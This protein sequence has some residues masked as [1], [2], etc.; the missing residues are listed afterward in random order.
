MKRLVLSILAAAALLAGTARAA[1]PEPVTHDATE[2]KTA[3]AVRVTG[4]LKIVLPAMNEPGHQWQ[5]ISN[6]PRI[7]KPQGEVKPVTGAK[8]P[9]KPVPWEISFVAQR[10]GRSILRFVYVT[11]DK[12]D[13][14]TPDEMREVTVRVQ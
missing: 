11:S 4:T 3:V 5:I 9:D 1:T 14:A 2:K 10:P 8:A 12:T 7:L 13:V 6:D